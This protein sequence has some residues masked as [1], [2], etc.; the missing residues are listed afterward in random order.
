MAL[1][2]KWSNQKKKKPFMDWFNIT[3]KYILNTTRSYKF[4]TSC[5]RYVKIRM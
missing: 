3:E 5:V 1:T 4:N 2:T